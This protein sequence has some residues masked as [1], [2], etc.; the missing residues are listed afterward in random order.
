MK[1]AY[2]KDVD[3][4]QSHEEM[5]RMRE[6]AMKQLDRNRD[7]T[8]SLEEFLGYAR[9]NKF[10]ENEEWKPTVDQEQVRRKRRWKRGEEEEE[11]EER[12]RGR[13]QREYIVVCLVS[14]D[15]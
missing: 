2:G 1:K 3:N 7:S 10:E 4:I 12:E 14:E 11:E 15:A 9:G 8:V 5:A 13:R 6:F